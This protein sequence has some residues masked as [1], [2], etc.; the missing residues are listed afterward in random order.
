MAKKSE[1][2]IDKAIIENAPMEAKFLKQPANITFMRGDI[3]S[4]QWNMMIELVDS[5]QE[6]INT[7]LTEGRKS[8]F[9]DEDYDEN[10]VYLQVPLSSITTNPEYYRYVEDVCESL[11]KVVVPVDKVG[12]DGH[13]YVEMNHIIDKA[14]IPKAESNYRKGYV[15]IVLDRSHVDTIFSL[16]RY[17]KYLKSVAKNSKS[18][19]TS[20]I[21]MFITAYKH[22]GE[23]KPLYKE[24]HKIFGFSKYERNQSTGRDE[25]VVEKYPN[26][27]Q[28][29]QKILKGA[30]DELKTLADNGAVDCYFDFEEIYPMGK[31][32]GEPEKIHFKIHTTDMGR[33][34]DKRGDESRY[35]LEMEKILRNDY[36][37][38]T[39]DIKQILALVNHDNAEYCLTKIAD[40]GEWM[41]TH[42]DLVKD[43]KKYMI[44]SLKNALLD[45]VEAAATVEEKI[46]MPT[47]GPST[48]SVDDETIA[49]FNDWVTG[50]QEEWRDAFRPVGMEDGKL[51]VEMPTRSS[52]DTYVKMHGSAI[53]ANIKVVVRD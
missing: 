20:R 32:R 45:T 11:M 16:S 19:Y 35:I 10:K 33:E 2:L 25:W 8:I 34:M 44:A 41:N 6:H 17:N 1:K 4:R 18:I 7:A 22:M 43:R 13:Q 51:V 40:I 52:Y 30:Q 46:N 42:S 49:A 21:Y 12:K 26:Y 5:M 36:D 9:T 27:R 28:F 39:S 14:R 53:V 37:F 3:S 15:E 47:E 29:K 48:E 38:K 50:I 24:L 31:K 23:W